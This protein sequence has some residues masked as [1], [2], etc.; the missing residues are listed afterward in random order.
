[1]GKYS[2][3]GPVVF[4][5]DDGDEDGDGKSVFVCVWQPQNE[6]VTLHSN[7][8]AMPSQCILQFIY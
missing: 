2:D 3:Y 1:M 4:D 8:C 7:A 6:E 5:S